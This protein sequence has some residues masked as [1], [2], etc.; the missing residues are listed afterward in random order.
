[1]SNEENRE[2]TRE[3]Y[4]KLMSDPNLTEEEKD[5][6]IIQYNQKN[7]YEFWSKVRFS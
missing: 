2:M 7:F 3:E 5:E 4:R 6:I 1:M